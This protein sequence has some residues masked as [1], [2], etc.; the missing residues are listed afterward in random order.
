MLVQSFCVQREWHLAVEIKLAWTKFW[1]SRHQVDIK[2][3]K[4]HPQHSWHLSLYNLPRNFLISNINNLLFLLELVHGMA[5]MKLSFWGIAVCNNTGMKNA[6]SSVFEPGSSKRT[7]NMLGMC[8][9]VEIKSP[10]VV[11]YSEF[12]VGM[13]GCQL[14]SISKLDFE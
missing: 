2:L 10:P 7:L 1:A 6:V 9:T 8:M 4:L 13:P 14:L 11:W 12:D 5:V 3:S